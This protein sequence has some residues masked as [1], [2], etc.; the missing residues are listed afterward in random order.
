M[1]ISSEQTVVHC[2]KLEKLTTWSCARSKKLAG[3]K[4][5]GE[6]EEEKEMGEVEMVEKVEGREAKQDHL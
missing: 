2:C 3:L 5:F 4:V 1:V 6:K